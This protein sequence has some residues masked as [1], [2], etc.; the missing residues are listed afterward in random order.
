MRNIKPKEDHF[1]IF[2]M[3]Y[4]LDVR[5]GRIAKSGTIIKTLAKAEFVSIESQETEGVFSTENEDD[6]WW[7][8]YPRLTP[9]TALWSQVGSVNSLNYIEDVNLLDVPG[10][11]LSAVNGFASKFTCRKVSY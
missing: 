5:Q 1:G 4:F 11:S 2:S 8:G 7:L 3:D 6:S 9:S 10:W